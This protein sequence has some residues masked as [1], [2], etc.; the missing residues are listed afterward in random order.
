MPGRADDISATWTGEL[1]RDRRHTR[2]AVLAA[3]AV[4]VLFFGLQLP[5]TAA[6]ERRG[7][8][9]QVFVLRT[10]RFRPP[11]P[12]QRQIP[13]PRALRIPVPDPTPDDPE[14]LAPQRQAV[15]PLVLADT[16]LV[17][18][19]PEAPADPR[20]A[21]PMRVGGDVLPPVELHAPTP[22]Y[23][24]IARAARIGGIVQLEAVIDATGAVTEVRVIKDLPLG[25]DQAA[26][27]AVR[28]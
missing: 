11:P 1:R 18:G 8:E 10:P 21:Q 20:P 17:L 4:H 23:P 14:P 13:E 5:E 12:R 6:G 3:V 7:S 9:R 26:V 16:D 2:W 25:L 15:A 27:T 22:H 24:E 28:R 19:L